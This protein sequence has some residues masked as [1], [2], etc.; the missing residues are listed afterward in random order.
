MI[1]L[2]P[3][4]GRALG[5]TLTAIAL[6]LSGC[7]DQKGPSTSQPFRQRLTE[8][9]SADEPIE[10][11]Y[12]PTADNLGQTGTAGGRNTG[13]V[14]HMTF[15][16]GTERHGALIAALSKIGLT[17][18][19]G[20]S[21]SVGTAY[22][23]APGVWGLERVPAEPTVHFSLLRQKHSEGTTVAIAVGRA[24]LLL[25]E[26]TGERARKFRADC[27]VFEWLLLARPLESAAASSASG[28]RKS[29]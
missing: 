20:K 12:V 16:P 8:Y 17:E 1:R 24:G 13:E 2:M 25:I 6:T 26:R 28:D 10:Y 22:P 11:V 15:V 14:R 5:L 23:Q 21:P 9:V 27:P 19:P 7:Q 4:L 18:P 29:P 3:E